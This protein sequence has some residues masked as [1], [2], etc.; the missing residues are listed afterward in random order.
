MNNSS[1]IEIIKKVTTLE[2]EINS[3]KTHKFSKLLKFNIK[4]KELELEKL[5]LKKQNLVSTKSFL[6]HFKQEKINVLLGSKLISHA[7][8]IHT[9]SIMRESM[10]K[11]WGYLVPQIS[12]QDTPELLENEFEIF[13]TGGNKREIFKIPE[14][15]PDNEIMN[16]LIS[17]LQ[18]FL[19]DNVSDV[20][21]LFTMESYIEAAVQ[22][23]PEEL[24]NISFANKTDWMLWWIK[25]IVCELLNERYC[26][27]NMSFILNYFFEHGCFRHK[28]N[29]FVINELKKTLPKYPEELFRSD[30][31]I[32]TNQLT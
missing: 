27:L 11:N 21:D 3:L 18:T 30:W 4:I 9:V 23:Q 14:N 24:R 8:E 1:L 17:T 6:R 25:D 20:L 16:Y 19:F 29:T 7:N 2:S 31:Y 22:N 26:V 28:N 15:Y 32:K 5:N 12:L 13:I 10:S